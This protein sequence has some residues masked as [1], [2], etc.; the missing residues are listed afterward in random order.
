MFSEKILEQ[1]TKTGTIAL[2]KDIPQQV[3]NIFKTAMDIDPHWHLQHQIAFQQHTDNA[4]SKTI[5]L[6]ATATVQEV[7]E[8]YRQ[9]WRQKVKGITIFR[10]NSKKR[11]T[12]ETGIKSGIK[13]CKVCI[14]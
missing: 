9:A 3:K 4:V 7:D 13:V 12:L 14:E 1:A 6:P 10:Y 2:I 5:N 11:S 8:I